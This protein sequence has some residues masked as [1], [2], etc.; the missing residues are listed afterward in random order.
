MVYRMSTLN[1]VFT[2]YASFGVMPCMNIQDIRRANL[3]AIV[4]YEGLSTAAAKFKIP[5]RQL[6]DMLKVRKPC[7]EKVIERM[8]KN[9][10]P[11]KDKGW[12]DIPGLNPKTLTSESKVKTYSTDDPAKQAIIEMILAMNTASI[13]ELRNDGSDNNSPE[14]EYAGDKE[15]RKANSNNK[16]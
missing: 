14:S 15:G 1:S 6:N 8:E 4:D 9:Y 5:D 7:G 11:N 3:Q 16:K 12:L 2:D 13:R 10:L